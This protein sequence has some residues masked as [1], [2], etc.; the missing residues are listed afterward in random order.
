MHATYV[1]S[2]SEHSEAINMNAYQCN[3]SKDVDC[4]LVSLTIVSIIWP[5]AVYAVHLASLSLTIPGPTMAIM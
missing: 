4:K 3:L 1:Y 5:A 2:A